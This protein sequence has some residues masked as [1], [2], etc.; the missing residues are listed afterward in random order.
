MI[1]HKIDSPGGYTGFAAD[2]ASP[3]VDWQSRA[4]EAEARVEER[5]LFEGLLHE[6]VAAYNACSETE[7][8]MTFRRVK[9][10]LVRIEA[11]RKARP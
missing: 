6:F 3:S 5:D 1:D 2:G 11:A 7:I 8:D 4:I 9:F 10:A